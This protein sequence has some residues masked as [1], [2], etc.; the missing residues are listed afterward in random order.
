MGISEVK[1]RAEM[2]VQS[3]KNTGMA[4]LGVGVLG[5]VWWEGDGGKLAVNQKGRREKKWDPGHA[6]GNACTA[7]CPKATEKAIRE[8]VK[9]NRRTWHILLEGQWMEEGITRYSERLGEEEQ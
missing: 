9:G 8:K 1:T 5:K 7:Q 2:W 3:R 4:A 6:L